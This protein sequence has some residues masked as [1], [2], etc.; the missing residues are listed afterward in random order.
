MEKGQQW[1]T[2]MTSQS[3]YNFHAEAS[4][5][6]AT[7]NESIPERKDNASKKFFSLADCNI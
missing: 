5:L 6:T 3:G 4:D 1:N 7:L 2:Q